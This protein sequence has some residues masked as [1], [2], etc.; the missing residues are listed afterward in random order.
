[1]IIRIIICVG[2]SCSVRGADRLAAELERLIARENLSAQ[3]EMVGSFC[4]SDCSNG[5]SVKVMDRQYHE[6]QPQ[7]AEAFF[8]QEIIPL[9]QQNAS[10]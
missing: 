10:A 2:S 9:V 4:M 6:V 1:M 8:Y 3:I 5:V 7:H